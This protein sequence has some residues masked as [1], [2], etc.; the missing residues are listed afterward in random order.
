MTVCRSL[1]LWD[2]EASAENASLAGVVISF[3]RPVK[4]AAVH[5]ERDTDAPFRLVLAGT[6]FA[7]AGIHEG[8]DMCTVQIAAHDS[9]AL[10]IRPVKLAVFLVELELLGSE[11]ATSRNN[12]RDVASVQIGPINGSVVCAGVAHIRPVNVAALDV[13][14]NAVGKSSTFIDDGLQVRTVGIRCQNA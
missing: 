10:A 3:L 14:H 5:I 1:A 9:H 6:T 13:D 7:L 8:L 12:V 4:F 11:G 2:F